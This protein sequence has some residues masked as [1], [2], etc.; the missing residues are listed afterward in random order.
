MVGARPQFV[1]A[2]AVSEVLRRSGGVEEVLVHTGQHY[3]ENMSGTFFSQMGIPHPDHRLGIG[4]GGHGWQTGK[5][6]TRLE[7]VFTSESPDWVLVY[8]DTNST[9][10]GAVAAAKM[11][12]PVA[13]VEAGLRSF[14]RAMPEEINRVLTDHVADMLLAPTRTAVENLSREGI[15]GGRVHLVGDVMYDAVLRYRDEAH[16]AS[17]VLSELALERGRYALATVHRAENT[18]DPERLATIFDAL[19]TVGEQVRVVVPLHPRTRN[20]LGRWGLDERYRGRLELV[21]PVGYFDMLRLVEEARVVVTDSGGVQKEAYFLGTSCVT[22]RSETEWI[23][24]VEIG[25]N[26][27]V[28]PIS[29]ER[30][31]SAILESEWSGDSGER[32]FGDGTAAEAIL[33]LLVGEAAR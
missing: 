22:V 23:E 25:Q 15:D 26:V 30:L 10:A 7:E 3:D 12:I 19:S 14:N 17:T 24:L 6:M 11:G 18:D 5:M 28:P 32:P 1:K 21:D 27:V 13:H 31:A 2:G 33:H 4:S 29:A 8:G 9:L 20:A 16:R